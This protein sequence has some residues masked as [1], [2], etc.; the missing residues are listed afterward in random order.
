MKISTTAWTVIG[1]LVVSGGLIFISSI[2]RP[3]SAPTPEANAALL[4]VAADDHKKGA[5]NSEVVLIEYLDF[6][7]EACGAYYPFV[8]QMEEEL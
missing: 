3:S 5:E 6:E 2:L 8:K 4:A 1:I 7:C